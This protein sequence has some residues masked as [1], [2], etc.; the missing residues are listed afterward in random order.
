[1]ED[2]GA[3][4]SKGIKKGGVFCG[5]VRSI[6]VG[7]SL[8]YSK[9]RLPYLGGLFHSRGQKEREEGRAPG[10]LYRKAKT[11]TSRF[12]TKKKTGKNAV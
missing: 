4:V 6:N 8:T 5:F 2:K 7:K 10:E 1:M 11:K 9:Q 3:N 12:L